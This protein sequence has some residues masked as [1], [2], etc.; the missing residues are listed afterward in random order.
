MAKPRKPSAPNDTDGLSSDDFALWSKVAKTTKPLPGRNVAPPSKAQTNETGLQKPGTRSVSLPSAQQEKAVVG[1]SS[2]LRS[3]QTPGVDRRTAERL[4]RGQL[5]IEA[6]IDLH[7]MTEAQ[8]HAAFD[9][10]ILASYRAERRVL[11]VITGKGKASDDAE[12]RTD[13]RPTGI[14]R[15]ALPGWINQSA[16]RPLVLAFT[17]AQPRDGGDGAVYILLKRVR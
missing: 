12:R 7:G 5:Q 3:G 6:R 4:R 1:T 14:I 10:F 16:I 13:S 17:R 8:A 11:L 9:A 15:R 2:S